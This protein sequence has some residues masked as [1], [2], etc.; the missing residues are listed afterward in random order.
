M[1]DLIILDLCAA[2]L[3]P[4]VRLTLYI[5]Q[6]EKDGLRLFCYADLPK[7]NLKR[8][9]RHKGLLDKFDG[10]L[11]QE[12]MP[13]LTSSELRRLADT[14]QTLWVRTPAE[15]D[16]NLVLAILGPRQRPLPR[17]LRLLG[18]PIAEQSNL[19]ENDA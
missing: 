8:A 1:I 9:L 16:Y 14:E 19:E 3:T 15:V 13:D 18:Q 2:L 7:L 5:S 10:L 6:A 17:A 11:Y 12:L 4:E